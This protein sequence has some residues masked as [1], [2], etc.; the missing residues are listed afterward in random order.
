VLIPKILRAF[1]PE[2]CQRWI[3][4]VKRQGLSE[5]HILKL[6]EFLGKEVDGAL[7]AQK[8]RGET[9]DHPNYVPS[10]AA[11]HVN[12]KQSKSGRKDRHTGD[13]FCAFCESR[14]HW[15]QECRKVTGVSERR[16]KL[17][18]A[19]RCFLCANRGHN[20][21]VCSKR[22]RGL[23]TRCKGAHHRSTCNETGAVTTPTTKTTNYLRQDRR[24]LSWL[25]LLTDSTYMCFGTQRTQQA[26]AL[27]FG[28]RQLV[29]L[30]R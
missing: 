21:I 10:A 29:K 4:H 9:L 3:V 15:A 8:T 18:S 11:L 26:H 27:C 23:C 12:F 14:G 7:T 22:G 30:R 24:R 2:F 1:P 25:Q 16:E 20:A 19:H 28:R 13:S 6:M 17:K 5:G